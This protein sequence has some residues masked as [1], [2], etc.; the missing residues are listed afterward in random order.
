MSKVSLEDMNG[1]LVEVKAELLKVRDMLKIRDIEMEEQLQELQSARDQV[2]R[3]D[4][5]EIFVILVD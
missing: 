2:G 5:T 4:L 1:E 3:A